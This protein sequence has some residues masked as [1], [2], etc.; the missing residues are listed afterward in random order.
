MPQ[1]LTATVH[2]WHEALQLHVVHIDPT[3]RQ[4]HIEAAAEYAASLDTYA[5]QTLAITCLNPVVMLAFMALVV[6]PGA[7][8]AQ[9]LILGSDMMAVLLKLRAAE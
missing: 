3:A 8:T 2:M 1:Q 5:L 4:V 9:A 7:S 6:L